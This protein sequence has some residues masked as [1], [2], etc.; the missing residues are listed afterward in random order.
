MVQ[1]FIKIF[2]YGILVLSLTSAC[3]SLNIYPRD[4][5]VKFKTNYA[6]C[7]KKCPT[8]LLIIAIREAMIC[9]LWFAIIFKAGRDTL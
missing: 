4:L 9:L 1:V 6:L 2:T 5:V 3:L 8:F 7:D